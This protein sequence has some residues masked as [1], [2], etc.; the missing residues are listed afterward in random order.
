MWCWLAVVLGTCI[1]D[2]TG[3]YSCSPQDGHFFHIDFGFVL[4][5]DPK[6][7]APSVRVRSG[8]DVVLND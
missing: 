6:P 1:W 3:S 5:D 7:G 2:I 4:G 8:R